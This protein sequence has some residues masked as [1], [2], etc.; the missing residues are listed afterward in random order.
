MRL[1]RRTRRRS[2]GLLLAEGPREVSR[3]IKAGLAIQ[4]VF[5]CPPL[6]EAIIQLPQGIAVYEVEP[7]LFVKM[8]YRDDPEGILAVVEE[9]QWSLDRLPPTTDQ[10]LYLVAVAMEKPGNLGA[11]VRTAE[12]AGVTAVLC[13]QEPGTAVDRFNPNAIRASTGAVFSLPTIGSDSDAVQEYLATKHMN[14]LAATPEGSTCYTEADYHGP[15]AIVIG[16]E[17]RGL[18]DDWLTIAHQRVSIPIHGQLVD[19]LNASNAAAVMLYEAQR[20]RGA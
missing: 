14:V 20:Q 7:D 3:A 13:A 9:P 17:D 5:I 10:S 1:R 18:S 11:M 16:P 8:T 6:L 12:A 19:S 2:E 15:L 4:D